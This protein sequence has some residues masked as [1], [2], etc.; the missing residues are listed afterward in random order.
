MTV[1]VGYLDEDGVGHIATDGM[2]SNGFVG[3]NSS[4]NKILKTK[5]ED[6]IMGMTGSFLLNELQFYK[7]LPDTEY[8]R[9]KNNSFEKKESVVDDEYF[10][11][12]L[13]Y[14]LKQK[15]DK[16]TFANDEKSDKNSENIGNLLILHGDLMYEFYGDDM[17]LI[18]VNKGNF[19]VLGSGTYHGQGAMN[20][21]KNLKLKKMSTK[22]MVI[23]AVKASSDSVVSVGNGIY[24]ANTKDYEVECIK[25]M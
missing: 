7:F 13:R 16:I 19:T 18:P 1:V 4:F 21:I 3:W 5:G 10:Y 22:Q 14:K 11:T 12:K 2:G 25:E 8:V 23:E 17:S 20:A 24:Y 6:L 15:I 9:K